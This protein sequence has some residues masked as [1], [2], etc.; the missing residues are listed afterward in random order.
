MC[1]VWEQN[2]VTRYLTLREKGRLRAKDNVTG[3]GEDSLRA[4]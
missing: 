4:L 3:R 1:F 2:M